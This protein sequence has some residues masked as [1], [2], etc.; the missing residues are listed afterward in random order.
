[1]VIGWIQGDRE[2]SIEEA[3]RSLA[4]VA[5]GLL[6]ETGSPGGGQGVEGK[7]AG[8]VMDTY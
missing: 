3:S 2:E 4:C 7:T 8:F 5:G 1:M 6:L